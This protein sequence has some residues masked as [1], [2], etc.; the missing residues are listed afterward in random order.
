MAYKDFKRNS[1]CVQLENNFK[2]LKNLV[3]N[4]IKVLKNKFFK[5]KWNEAGNNCKKQW[6]TINYFLKN[7]SNENN[8]SELNI[9][10]KLTCNTQEIAEGL[11]KY[12]STI[13]SKIIEELQAEGAGVAG[14]IRFDEVM[15]HNN[16]FI[17]PTDG[18]EI[19]NILLNLKSSAAPGHD[20]ITVLDLRNL[21][22]QNVVDILVKLINNVLSSGIFPE[23]LKLV[24][25]RP[26]FKSGDST[27]MSNY[28]PI[29]IISVF[30]KLLENVIKTRM[31]K[32]IDEYIK[33]DPYQY[34]FVKGSNPLSTNLDLMNLI[35]NDLDQGNITIAI[36]IDLRKAFDVVSHELLINKLENMGFRGTI[37][38]LLQSYLTNRRQYIKMDDLNSS[39]LVNGSGVPQGSVLG[40]LFY[41][42][43]VLSLRLAGLKSRYFAFAD[44][45]ALLYSGK[46]IIELS[47]I[48]NDDLNLYYRW[49]MQNNLKINIDKTKYLVFRQKNKKIVDVNILINNYELQ[50]SETVRYLGL[51][52]DEYL[53]WKP[54]VDYM[55][56]KIVPVMGA[57]MRCRD[58]LS[59]RAKHQIYNACFLSVMRYLLPIWGVCNATNFK[60]MQILQNRVIK[61]L[62]NLHFRTNTDYL[63]EI[64]KIHPINTVLKI[65]Q[66][67]TIYKIS[68]NMQKCNTTFTMANEIH[69]FN[70]RQCSNIYLNPV[71]TNVALHNPISEAFNIFN[72][73]P[74]NIKESNTIRK[75]VQ[76]I[77]HYY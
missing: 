48:V 4:K 3:N 29:S 51:V 18:N 36:F 38:N 64:L 17:T 60:K 20:D 62:F 43:F 37:G 50:K 22:N 14:D 21:Q 47:Y 45:T 40:P 34:G 53:S 77:K 68:N 59:C 41:S 66:C 15:C 76:Q 26:I 39:I 72:H 8:I 27:V 2:G 61:T 12:F 24:K 13:G 75:F 55:R 1:R 31:T 33:F 65:D 10:G 46:D 69:T 54:H 52:L 23:E 67:K 28:R 73:L 30:S 58:F 11:N 42:V 70:T 25:V 35:V 63:Y 57:I 16:F 6:K 5:D 49:L 19:K 9:D 56:N 74:Q 71:R 7:S 44:D 32:F